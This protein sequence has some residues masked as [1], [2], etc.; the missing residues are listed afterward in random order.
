MDLSKVEE[1][2]FSGGLVPKGRVEM[3][4]VHFD[5]EKKT[6]KSGGGYYRA[7]LE[8]KSGKYA[9]SRTYENVTV[10]GPEGYALQ[11]G[12]TILRY[13]AECTHQAHLKPH[14]YNVNS[15]KELNGAQVIVKFGVKS[16]LTKEGK[17][18][19]VNEPDGYGTPREDS[20]NNKFYVAWAS[21]DQKWETDELPPLLNAPRSNGVTGHLAA[22]AA[23]QA[24]HDLNDDIPL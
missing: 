20:S 8:V 13:I 22:G 17:P 19:L 3:C 2:G 4:S 23:F 5:D 12:L 1:V 18:M 15:P 6:N 9:G 14:F 24:P 16:I 7:T 11:R 21:D 10:D